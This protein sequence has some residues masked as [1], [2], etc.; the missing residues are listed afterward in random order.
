MF[1]GRPAETRPATYLTSGEKWTIRRSRASRDCVRLYSLQS[2]SMA[3]ASVSSTIRLCPGVGGLMY[4]PQSLRAH[5]SVQLGRGKIAVPQEFLHRPQV[6]TTVEEVGGVG[7]AQG[8]GVG[9]AGS[10]AVDYAPDI[11]RR[12]PL[13]ALVEE[14]S[15]GRGLGV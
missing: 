14:E 12:E 7:V 2:R 5:V 3:T 13:P 15:L 8:V 11:P 9:R 4:R 10:P 6:G 1:W